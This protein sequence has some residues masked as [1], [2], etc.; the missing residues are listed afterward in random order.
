MRGMHNNKQGKDYQLHMQI[1]CLEME[2]VRR[3]AERSAALKRVRGIDARLQAVEQEKS[4]LLRK[5]AERASSSPTPD[6]SPA[7]AAG[8]FHFQYGR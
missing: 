3:H 5:L 1:T 6:S 8:G 7:P 2:K 4:A